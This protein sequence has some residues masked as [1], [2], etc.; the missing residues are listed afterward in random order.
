M[1]TAGENPKLKFRYWVDVVKEISSGPITPFF[2]IHKSKLV[3]GESDAS[4]YALLVNDGSR[5]SL[6]RIFA[7]EFLP[8]SYRSF[9]SRWKET[10]IPE[11]VHA[12]KVQSGEM[13]R[14]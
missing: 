8:K 11:I 4:Q 10:D 9:N 3:D 14:Q 1:N 12:N 5:D 13:L 2:L 6:I 7:V